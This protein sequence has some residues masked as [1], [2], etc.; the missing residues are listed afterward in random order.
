M[1][2]LRLVA[3]SAPTDDEASAFRFDILYA[4]PMSWLFDRR[5]AVQQRRAAVQRE[6]HHLERELRD[7]DH[8]IAVAVLDAAEFLA[9]EGW[10]S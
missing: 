9:S 7:V 5:A 1:S 6:V 4:E 8:R 2:Q 3:T 10:P